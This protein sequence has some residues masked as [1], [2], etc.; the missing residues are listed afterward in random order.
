MIGAGFDTLG[1]RLA[2]ESDQ[3]EVIEMDH[4][5]TQAVKRSALERS[6]LE[7]PPNL[8]FTTIDLTRETDPL[9]CTDGIATIYILEGV[10]MYLPEQDVVR[11]LE[12]I[13]EVSTGRAL[14]IF[15]FMT[16]W[17]NGDSRFSPRSRLIEL[18]L[19]WSNEP[20]TWSMEPEK[21]K[22]FL[23]AHGFRLVEMVLTRE[24]SD[25]LGMEGAM[26]EGENLVVCE[27]VLD[28]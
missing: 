11:L 17:P 12:R 24:F 26:L 28:R 14:V 4:P 23:S 19:N 18:W 20:F 9:P 6:G 1:I 10:L 13:R 2:R 5:A 15:S 8:R 25:E 22:E 7:V 21:M 3:L 16:R 27:P